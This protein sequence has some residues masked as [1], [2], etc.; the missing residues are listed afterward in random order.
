L[1]EDLPLER[2]SA[3]AFFSPFHFHRLF[4]ALVGETP[5]DFVNRL[6]LERAANSLF[7]HH[8][9]SITSIAFSSGFS[10]S[11]AFSRAFKKY[12]KMPASEFSKK[13]KMES[14]KGKALISPVDYFVQ[15]NRRGTQSSIRRALMKSE[16][17]SMPVQHVAYVANMEGYSEEKIGR[18][19][20]KLCG[21]AVTRNL[22]GKD[23]I[24]IGVSYDNPDITPKEKCRY[25]ACLS[26]PSDVTP[27]KGIGVMDIPAGQHAVF[28]F[29]GRKDEIGT[30]YQSIFAK[31]L[32]ES[33]FQPDDHPAYE[34]YRTTPEQHPE[35]KFVMD[36]CVP[37]KPL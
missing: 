20:E 2:L 15:A 29:E 16:V 36:I 3:A 8:E 17:K 1:A 5:A 24:M 12:F 14:K 18:A 34:I 9:E 7:F 23:A 26:I 13:C 28:V 21:W 35:G 30:A 32:P 31:W 6:R 37:V 11:A 25:Y 33:G 22:L 27:P 4:T 10:S 19:W